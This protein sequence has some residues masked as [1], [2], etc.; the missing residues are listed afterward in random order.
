MNERAEII[1]EGLK[2]ITPFF[3]GYSEVHVRRMLREVR[4]KIK[5]KYW[6]GHGRSLKLTES[7]IDS[8]KEFIRKEKSH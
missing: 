1:I 6:L 4:S 8:V 2:N 7:E 5:F 3:G